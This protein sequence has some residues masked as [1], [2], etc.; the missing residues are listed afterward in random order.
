M[1]NFS[2]QWKQRPF[3]FLSTISSTVSF[4]TDCFHVEEEL[5]LSDFESVVSNLGIYSP[6]ENKAFL[7]FN[8]ALYSLANPRTVRTDL[9]L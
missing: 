3:A 1:L 5:A 4:L 6:N 9:S 2:S 7:S 8:L